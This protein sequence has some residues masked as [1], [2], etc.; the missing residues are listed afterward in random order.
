MKC[1]ECNEKAIILE[2]RTRQNNVIRR[3]YKCAQDHKFTTLE[4]LVDDTETQIHP[5]HKATKTRG[6]IGLSAVWFGNNSSSGT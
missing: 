4:A 5:K 6:P 1:P 2:T 3:R